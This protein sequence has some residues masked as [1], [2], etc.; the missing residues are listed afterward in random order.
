[1]A[2]EIQTRD[3]KLPRPRGK[4]LRRLR[5]AALLIGPVVALLAGGYVYVT[6][7]RFVG[8]EN[9]YVK[10]EKVMLSSHVAGMV[11]TVLVRENQR[12]AAGDPLLRLDENGFRIALA[13]AE[14][15][16]RRAASD[17]EAIKAQALRRQVEL[18]LARADADYAMRERDRQAE[19]ARRKVASRAQL[20]AVTHAFDAARIRVAVIEQEYNEI[21][22]SLGGDPDMGV[23]EHPRYLAAKAVRDRA[24]LDLAHTTVRAPFAGI[25]GN[26]PEPGRF[27]A[28][29]QAA[30]SLVA[31]TGAW[32]EANFKET[33]L[34]HV[35]V[36]QP[37]AITIDSYPGH[38][39]QGTIES[40]GAATSAEFSVLPAQ[41]ATGNWV[42]VV[43]RIPVRISIAQQ[44]GA[45]MLRAG[46][47]SEV[48]VDTG[49]HNRLA[50]F[51]AT[52]LPQANAA[53][54]QP[55]Q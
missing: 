4:G 39:W 33:E 45:P 7:G 35:R 6:G 3:E 52:A 1:M 22:A 12:V 43:Q 34:T 5:R 14:A 51:A 11:E 40:I 48:E 2:D 55:A 25:V 26:L 27:L 37:V 16:L 38:R 8:T 24:A 30:L 50:R 28:A 21:V 32:I 47:S 19:L 49:Y 10:A 17:I 29:G 42:K 54:T 18:K 13:R 53:Q 9:A 20:D 46:M 44:D 15:D 31:D 36:G 41:N 23:T